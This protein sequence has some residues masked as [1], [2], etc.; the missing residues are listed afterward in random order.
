MNVLWFLFETVK[1]LHKFNRKTFQFVD[2]I[3]F[4]EKSLRYELIK[5]QLNVE[6]LR[7]WRKAKHVIINLW[8]FCRTRVI[9]GRNKIENVRI[10]IYM[11]S[12][13]SEF[14]FLLKKKN[15]V[16]SPDDLRAFTFLSQSAKDF[17]S[18]SRLVF[19]CS[20]SCSNPTRNW[21]ELEN[22][23][24]TDAQKN[25]MIKGKIFSLMVE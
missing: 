8:V 18:F 12:K 19:P 15:E 11:W 22:F 21:H 1:N 3:N 13:T 4:I 23:L 6:R 16:N 7:I 5:I 2:L 20:V 14:L 25:L 9:S 17:F 24:F 10:T